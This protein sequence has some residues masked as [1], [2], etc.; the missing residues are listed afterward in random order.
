LV[1]DREFLFVMTGQQYD[2]VG[3]RRASVESQGDEVE[4][5]ETTLPGSILEHILTFLPDASVASATR[6]CKA[7]HHE[8]GQNSPELWNHLLQRHGWPIPESSVSPE[9]DREASRA[10]FL[11]HYTA[12]R[13]LRAMKQGAA[14]ILTK[15]N[16]AET[17]MSY[18]DFSAR[19]NA[20]SQVSSFEC[21]SVQ[22]W[23]PC[24][25][26]TAYARDCS[27][28]L[29]E[30]VPRCG[31]V[32]GGSGGGFL[33]ADG[34]LCREIVCRRVDPY[35]NTKRRH[36]SILSVGL[37][38]ETIGCLC[39][40]MA[41]SVDVEAHVLVVLSRDDFLV[42]DGDYSKSGHDESL[43]V[44]D[45]GEAVLNFLLSSD[46]ADHQLL[47][48]MDFLSSNEGE[49]GDVEILASRTV[50]ACGHGRFM[51]EVSISI[52][53]VH[54]TDGVGEDNWSMRLIYRQLVLFSATAGA[55]VWMGD[56]NGDAQLLPRHLD[57][58]SLPF[59]G[60]SRMHCSVLVVS[61]LTPVLLV[62]SIGP[63][64]IVECS[65]YVASHE[66]AGA[67]GWDVVLR[68]SP[69]V[70]LVSTDAITVQ[71]LRKTENGRIVDRKSK[72]GF[73]RRF[74]SATGP[75][76]DSMTVSGAVEV[77]S[78]A[79][80][81]DGHVVLLGRE[82]FRAVSRTSAHP[83]DEDAAPAFRAAAVAILIH[84]ASR[85]EVHRLNLIDSVG[86]D[87]PTPEL[88]SSA[89]GGTI[90]IALSCKGIIM[91]GSRVR[92]IAEPRV[93]QLDDAAAPVSRSAKKKKKKVVPKNNKKDGF[94]RGMSL[95][96]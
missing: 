40:V 22:V 63:T 28:R 95:R 76:C 20:P 87:D 75:S 84:V 67:D 24:H 43:R 57:H 59:P 73:C 65:R 68:A 70:V 33:G 61:P 69:T 1:N 72:V 18:Q 86:E 23:S 66:I 15:L 49:V 50:A 80:L 56:S 14:A 25:I 52:P 36:C 19:K 17:E 74:P 21:V 71:V 4:S 79:R 92:A 38:D 93:I 7:W 53:D 90:G 29:F 26:L 64:G 81:G 32:G 60:A 48:V 46:D 3:G 8:I 11:Q 54:R 88:S 78:L 37:D 16:V 55:I 91:T 82:Y 83:P 45:I 35:R 5:L 34:L 12:V 96:G 44:I 51:I 58:M 42:G 30:T 94:A 27:L 41:D 6:V 77:E 2:L 62:A 10:A 31:G 9:K 39:R 85:R 13:D 47:Q 89:S